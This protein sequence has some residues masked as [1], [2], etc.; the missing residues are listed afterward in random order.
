MKNILK[1]RM[2]K[3]KKSLFFSIALYFRHEKFYPK[4]AEESVKK[5][6]CGKKGTVCIYYTVFRGV[7]NFA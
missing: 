1:D 7:M 3:D 6:Q 2:K 4:L 5:I